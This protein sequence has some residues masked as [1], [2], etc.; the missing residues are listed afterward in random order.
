MSNE[1]PPVAKQSKGPGRPTK[2]ARRL[3]QINESENV[4]RFHC[5]RC[6]IALRVL[7]GAGGIVAIAGKEEITKETQPNEPIDNTS[8]S[9]DT[10][11]KSGFLRILG[12]NSN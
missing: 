4:D 6:K 11:Q 3:R 1:Q 10:R 9:Q 12:R 8:A 2:E 5:P 7:P